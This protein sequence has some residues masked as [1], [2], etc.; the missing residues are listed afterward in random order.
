MTATM[1][2]TMT[3]IMTATLNNR[4]FDNGRYTDYDTSKDEAFK[5]SSKRCNHV[6]N[7]DCNRISTMTA[8]LNKM[9]IIKMIIINIPP[10]PLSGG[11]P[12]GA[13]KQMMR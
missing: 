6:F 3:L 11:I 12:Q 9:I 5:L 10:T 13:N 2:S 7:H 4:R 1:F 8:T